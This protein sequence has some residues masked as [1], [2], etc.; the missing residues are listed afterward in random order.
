VEAEATEAGD[1]SGGV[2]IGFKSHLCM[3]KYFDHGTEQRFSGKRWCVGHLRPQGAAVAV[4]VAYLH[5]GVE[6]GPENMEV[7]GQLGQALSATGLPFIV[8]ADWNMEASTLRSTGWLDRLGGEVVTMPGIE[9][10][11]TAGSGRLIDF[12]V[13]SKRFAAAVQARGQDMTAPWKP[14]AALILR[15]NARPRSIRILKHIEPKEIP[16]LHHSVAEGAT[17]DQCA[18]AAA[19]MIEEGQIRS[20]PPDVLTKHLN[21]NPKG[22]SAIRL[23]TKLSVWA[24]TTELWLCSQAGIPID[25]TQPYLGRGQYPRLEWVPL[26]ERARPEDTWGGAQAGLWGAISA[27]L[28]EAASVKRSNPG[29]Q[30]LDKLQGWLSKQTVPPPPE[31]GSKLDSLEYLGWQLDLCSIS[32]KDP[33]E[34]S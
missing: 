32:S 7:L 3:S 17:W 16:V 30:Q 12:F 8:A 14:H 22:Q 1:T 5:T 18:A 33:G 34:L 2:V 21:R 25:E 13:V 29:S 9:S 19:L 4:G 11:C 15:L 31:D 6:D 20:T 10:T 26:V 24:L 23:G 27:R 28:K